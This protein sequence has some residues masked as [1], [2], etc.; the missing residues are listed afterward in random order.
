[1]AVKCNQRLQNIYR[2]F[3]ATLFP[4]AC[5]FPE[6]RFFIVNFNYDGL[7]G[8]MLVDAV[9]ARREQ[10]KENT[11]DDMDVRLSSMNGGYLDSKSSPLVTRCD[12]NIHIGKDIFR[13]ILP[14]GTYCVW[15]NT[16][17]SLVSLQRQVYPDTGNPSAQDLWKLGWEQGAVPQVDFPWEQDCE[18]TKF[19]RQQMT[20]A[21]KAVFQ[22]KRIHFIG[23]QGHPL[24][25]DSL[26]RIFSALQAASAVSEKHWHVATKESDPERVL[27]DIASCFLPQRYL[28]DSS[29]RHAAFGPERVSFYG[30][31]ADWIYKRP[32]H[33]REF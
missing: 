11:T 20:V 30:D 8:K 3:L 16:D 17:E 5:V 29:W 14:H 26:R 7:V 6:S 4:G 13:Q 33:P 2:S 28:Q 25:M 31:F 1:M 21:T 18:S 32:H 10:S 24:M 15:E 27:F 12:M 22:A 19:H 9:R 23:L